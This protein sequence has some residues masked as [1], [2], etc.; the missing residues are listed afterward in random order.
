MAY[1]KRCLT[2]LGLLIILG[3][4]LPVQ[5]QT[6]VRL[7]EMS[8]ALWPEYD[9]PGVLVIYSGTMAGDVALPVT[10]TFAMPAAGS[11]SAT[12]GVDE[13]GN[14]RYRKYELRTQGDRILVSYSLPYRRFQMEYYLDL[15]AGQGSDKEFTLTYQADY[16]VQD[17]R[18]EV[19][20]PL[21]ASA[22]QTDPAA[23][24]VITESQLPLHL[25]PV[26][27]LAQGQSAGVTV[28]Y[29]REERRLSAEILGVPTPG[30]AE[31]E[32][33]PRAAGEGIPTTIIL[34]GALVAVGLAA[35]A[36]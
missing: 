19:Q 6:P 3:M 1:R 36:W 31:F 28:R 14:F 30:P 11:L 34:A 17:F 29:H 25:V 35:G 18:F 27:A 22:F 8:V 32:D 15:L 7:D 13:Q 12:A 21:G 24:S 4:A 26:G 2:L 23:G 9:R 16:P 10:I 33:V 5:A 20:E